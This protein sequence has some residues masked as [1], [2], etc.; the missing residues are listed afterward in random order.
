VSGSVRGHDPEDVEILLGVLKAVEQDANVTQRSVARDLGIALGLANAYM[1]RCVRKGLIKI[2]QAPAR[3]Y[4]YYLTPNGFAEKARLTTQYLSDSF[5]FFRTARAQCAELFSTSI[6]RGW[7]RVALAG[8][9][10]LAEI[11]TLCARDYPVTLAGIVDF[12][13]MSTPEG[14]PPVVRSVA[15]LTGGVDGVFV[16]HLQA[17]QATYEA[18]V[19]AVGIGRVLAPKMLDVRTGPQFSALSGAWQKVIG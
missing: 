11:A 5:A 16:T 8:A 9:G 15:E 6:E 19:K 4:A 17:P 2:Q 14:E 7:Q 13:A 10:D 3:R 1:R 12:R 18:M